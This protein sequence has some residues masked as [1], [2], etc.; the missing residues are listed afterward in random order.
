MKNIHQ[1]LSKS[2]VPK[3]QFYDS[4]LQAKIDWKEKVRHLKQQFEKNWERKNL[5]RGRGALAPR[6]PLL[7]FQRPKIVQTGA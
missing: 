6:P 2:K 5:Q 4:P 3:M 7:V 1:F